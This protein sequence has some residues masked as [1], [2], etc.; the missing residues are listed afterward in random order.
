MRRLNC[1]GSS[2]LPRAMHSLLLEVW[3]ST[4]L[5]V[6][7]V[8]IESLEEAV[9]NSLAVFIALINGP[10]LVDMV[11]GCHQRLKL[12]VISLELE[13]MWKLF[14]YEVKLFI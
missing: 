14:E 1:P 7:G 8:P 10:S 12:S 6:C 9:R 4:K 13:K 5:S 2:I 11:L 3:L